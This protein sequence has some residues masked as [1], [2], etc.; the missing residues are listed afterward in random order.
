MK[1]TIQD[2]YDFQLQS[3]AELSTQIQ[4]VGQIRTEMLNQIYRRNTAYD[5]GAMFSV[6]S[7][8]LLMW[9]LWRERI[10]K[11]NRVQKKAHK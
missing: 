1:P 8:L 5:I 10:P 9:Y 6:V 4:E 3:H 7:C 2:I 11:K